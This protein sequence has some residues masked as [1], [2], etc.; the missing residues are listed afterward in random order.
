M[1][2]F[3][4]REYW[5]EQVQKRTGFLCQY[6]RSSVC[7][8]TGELHEESDQ[9]RFIRAGCLDVDTKVGKGQ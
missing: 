7:S 8:L 9:F 3:L 6:V 1:S 5:M 4:L 2:V